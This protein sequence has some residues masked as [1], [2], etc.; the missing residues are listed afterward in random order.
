MDLYLIWSNEHR[1]WW[2]AMARGYT[3]EIAAAGR[4]SR[5]A[6]LRCC[7]ARDQEPGQPMPEL[8]VRE[9][10]LMLMLQAAAAL[11]SD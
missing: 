5:E 4:Y 1:A 11:S 3:T 2:R 6:A 9:A 10:D 7:R 8:P